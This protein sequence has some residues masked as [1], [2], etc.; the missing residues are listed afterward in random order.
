MSSIEELRKIGEIVSYKEDEILF[1]QGEKGDSAFLILKGTVAVILNSIYDG[2]EI[3]IAEIGEGD[4]VGE[5]A[6]LDES[7]RA[8]TVKCIAPM[9]ALKIKEDHF[10]DFIKMNPKYAKGLLCS[11][12][13]RINTTREKIT[14]RMNS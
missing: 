9:V 12:S 3:V 5:M 10:T 11:L 1:Q 6:V 13:R 2:S 14:E 4:I 7:R 8:A